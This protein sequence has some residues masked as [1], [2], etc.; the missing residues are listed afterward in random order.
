MYKFSCYCPIVCLACN[1]FTFQTE[2]S[3]HNKDERDQEHHA[4]SSELVTS[5]K[6][7]ISTGGVFPIK[8]QLIPD[9]ASIA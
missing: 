5:S 6:L 1:L 8:Y 9:L 2:P 7:S 4:L 3:N